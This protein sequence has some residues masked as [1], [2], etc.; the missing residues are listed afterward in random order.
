LHLFHH[1]QII[2]AIGPN[3]SSFA[4]LELSGT[5]FSIVGYKKSFISNFSPPVTSSE[6]LSNAS[7]KILDILKAF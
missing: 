5:F 7:C 1:L 6:P 2:G 3:V 4:I